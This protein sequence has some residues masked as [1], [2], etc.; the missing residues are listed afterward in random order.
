MAV[1]LT[2][3]LVRALEPPPSADGRGN[4]RITYDASL[5]GFGA[6]ITSAGAV[7]FVLN[8]RR[9]SDGRE[10]RYTIGAFPAWSVAAA[11]QRAAELRRAIDSGGDPLGELAAERGAPTVADL[12]ERFTA[13]HLPKL[14]PST[15]GMYRAIIANEIV[16]ALGAMKV[17]AVEYEHIDRLHA[18]ITKRAPYM[19][20]RVLTQASKLF[21]LA[22]LW[23]MRKDNPVRGVQRNQEHK[24]RRYLSPHELSRLVKAL[25]EHHNSQAAD[26]LRLLLLT[27]AR[28]TEVL[29][30]TWNQIDLTKGIWTKPAAA[31]KQRTEHTIPL[32]APARQLLEKIRK[33]NETAKF[34]FPGPGPRGYRTSVK[35]DWAQVCKAAGIPSLRVHDLRHS[36]ASQLAS[37]GVGLH[38]IGRLL[39]HTQPQTTHR[40]AHL[41]DDPLRQATERV[42]AVIT[43]S[44]SA[45]VI[46]LNK[47]GAS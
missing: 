47:G 42:G 4:N 29:S 15:R 3:R 30:A 43:G 2:D 46:P 40:Y 41:L 44:P 31:T 45:V 37:A 16:P 12:C 32:S 25:H 23:K 22:V 21:A 7:S 8:Y 26:V 9:K 6:R 27:G 18:K 10:R 28:K 34:V 11:R 17:A 39:G 36:Y 35:R 13:E 1:K 33:Q 24:R 20:N 38:L 14:R 5:P 19:A